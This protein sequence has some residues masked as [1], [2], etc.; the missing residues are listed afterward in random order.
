MYGAA[1]CR[2]YWCSWRSCKYKIAEQPCHSCNPVKWLLLSVSR[3]HGSKVLNE[4]NN[5]R[6]LRCWDK[7]EKMDT[8]EKCSWD[9]EE[10]YVLKKAWTC[11]W[12]NAVVFQSIC[13]AE[14]SADTVLY[15]CDSEYMCCRE[16]CRHC[17]IWLWFRV[18]VLQR[19]VQTQYY[20]PLV[21]KPI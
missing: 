17:T 18:H 9:D 12:T 21:P 7:H 1:F 16:Q 2:C 14:N 11:L 4:D 3:S 5:M 13:A 6:F 10:W 20:M 19:T 15:G 8:P